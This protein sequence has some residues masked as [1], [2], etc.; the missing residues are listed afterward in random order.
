MK[1]ENSLSP[2][3]IYEDKNFLAIDKPAGLLVHPTAS[4]KEDTLVEWLKERYPEVI[5]VGDLPAGRQVIQN[6][7]GIVHRL[8]R[9]TSGI[10]LV[11][12]NQKYFEYLKRLFQTRAIK[13]TYRALVRGIVMPKKGIIEKEIKIKPGT[14]KRTVFKGRSEKA[15]ITE[16]KV[17][18]HFKNFSWIE[19]S[20]LT[21]RT[22]QIRVHLASIGHPVVEDKV[23]GPKKP[24]EVGLPNI[25]RQMLHAYSLEFSPAPGKRIKLAAS[26]PEDIK[27]TL[28]Y[29]Q[30]SAN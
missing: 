20:P 25:N 12:K 3:V 17:L 9:D 1:T 15:A 22:H 10:M 4:S 27:S 8:D 29:L 13:K 28:Q 6:R 14:V 30:K 26:L 7:P 11:A 18:R 5:K 21:G 16:Y 24:K 23:Y 2:K 19:A